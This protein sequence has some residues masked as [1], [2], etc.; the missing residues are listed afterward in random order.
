[1]RRLSTTK[2]SV[3]TTA[4]TAV[5]SSKPNDSIWDSL[6]LQMS[7]ATNMAWG[8]PSPAINEGSE[9]VDKTW[10]TSKNLIK[11]RPY[12]KYMTF[13]FSWLT[14]ALSSFWTASVSNSHLPA[15]YWALRWLS[16]YQNEAPAIESG[17]NIPMHKK[18]IVH[19]VKS[20][21]NPCAEQVFHDFRTQPMGHKCARPWTGW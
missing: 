11:S 13:S 9:V 15:L 17:F 21:T 5:S 8:F 19:T 14:S 7:S 6:N 10:R 3:T 12:L 4:V 2:E 18:A 16:R 20:R 1:M